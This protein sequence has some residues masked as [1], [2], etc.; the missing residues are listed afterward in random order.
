VIVYKS[1]A[2]R[3]PSPGSAHR[4]LQVP[5]DDARN[6][7]DIETP[8][9]DHVH[10]VL[11]GELPREA[12]TAA[13]RADLHLIETAVH[14]VAIGLRSIRV[15]D[16]SVAVM[17]RLP[18]RPRPGVDPIRRLLAWLWA[19]HTLAL[20]LRPAH[21]LGGM[22]A[23]A[24]AAVLLTSAPSGPPVIPAAFAV[25]ETPK[26]Y[27]QFRFEAANVSN[28]ELAGSFTEWQPSYELE[29]TAPGVWSIMVP[30]APG[31]HDYTFVVDGERW[32]TDPYAARV[33]DSFGGSNSRLFLPAPGD[34]T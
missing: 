5:S 20:T 10:A 21:A 26:L 31:V 13:E 30:L 8:M 18:A 16:L 12:L 28:V 32:V 29:E 15:P 24:L 1:L 9:K 25:R 22:A 33:P 6:L 3:I 2:R 23:A 14:E 11:D 7:N 4:R 34:A 17:D 19:P 27:V